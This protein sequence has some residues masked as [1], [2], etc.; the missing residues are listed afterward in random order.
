MIAG[1]VE[2]AGAFGNGTDT[3]WTDGSKTS[4]GGVGGGV[5]WYEDREDRQ[6]EL[7]TVIKRRRLL[8]VGARAERPRPTY[9]DR[10]IL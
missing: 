1:A 3:I 2:E 10:E 9:R 6:E 4:Q 8:G 7:P 5:T